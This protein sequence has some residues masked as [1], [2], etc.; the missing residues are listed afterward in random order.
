MKRM[1]SH[2]SALYTESKFTLDDDYLVPGHPVV[3]SK[4]QYTLNPIVA[5]LYLCGRL[6]IQLT[7]LGQQLVL[8]IKCL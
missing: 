5:P 2:T 6:C 4:I 1:L 7:L 8:S 3:S